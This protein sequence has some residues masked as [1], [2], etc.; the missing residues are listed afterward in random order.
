MADIN[1]GHATA[2]GYARSKGFSGTEEEFAQLMANYGTVGQTATQAAQT[3]TT[4][5]SEA[6]S[7]ASNAALSATNAANSA[8]E[9]A[10]IVENIIDDTL[11]QEGKAADAKVTGDRIGELRDDLHDEINIEKANR[12]SADDNLQEQI[13]QIVVNIKQIKNMVG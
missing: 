8:Q 3:A 4:K 7:S 10:D 5:A 2:Y 1:L 6:A 12:I 11:T 9:A 13:N